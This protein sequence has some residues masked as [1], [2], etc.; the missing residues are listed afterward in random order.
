MTSQS[1]PNR[2]N[3]SG[4]RPSSSQVPLNKPTPIIPVVCKEEIH[5]PIENPEIEIYEAEASLVDEYIEEVCQDEDERDEEKLEEIKGDP[6]PIRVETIRENLGSSQTNPG[7][8]NPSIP[9]THQ[10]DK[11]E[12]PDIKQSPTSEITCIDCH[13]EEYCT[14]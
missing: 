8:P 11:G 2:N 9:M 10:E 3:T 5:E 14:S 7:R 4:H 13:K 1:K 12:A 6:E